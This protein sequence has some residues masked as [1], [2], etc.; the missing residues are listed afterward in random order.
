MT[1]AF[2]LR[3]ASRAFLRDGQRS[4][5]AVLCIMFG[6]MSVVSMQLIADMI[7]TTLNVEPRVQLG[8]DVRLHSSVS[9]NNENVDSITQQ[10]IASLDALNAEGTLSAYTLL[11]TSGSHLL[12]P[13]GTGKVYYLNNS[14]VGIDPKSYPLLGQIVINEPAGVSLAS[15]LAQP[16]SSVVSRDLADKLGLHM[17]DTYK[18][19]GDPG[20]APVSLRLAGIAGQVPSGRGDTIYYSLDTARLV[21]GN[22][23]PANT[24]LALWGPGGPDVAKLGQGWKATLPEALAQQNADSVNLF[25]FMLKGAGILGLLVGG[26]GVANTLQVVLARRRLEVATLKTLG[27]RRRDLLVLFGIETGLLGIVGG[28]LGVAVGTVIAYFLMSIMGNVGAFLLNFTADP[29]IL[30]GGVLTGVLTAIIFGLFTIVRASSVRPAVLLR[31]IPVRRSWGT[32]IAGVALLVVLLAL[33]TGIS[34]LVMGNLLSGLEVVGA[35]VIG[36][37]LLGL[38]LTGVLLLFLSLPTPGL[39]VATMARRNLKRQPL[40]AAIA[41]IALF[42]GVFAIGFATTVIL[43]AQA[44][45]AART[46]PDVPYNLT[47]YGTQADAQPIAAALGHAGVETV[48]SS[49]QLQ[50]H[51]QTLGGQPL[52]L[53][54]IEGRD[55]ADADWD[56]TITGAPLQGDAAL[57]PM[58][59]PGPDVPV[60]AGDKISVSIN[61]VAQE[62]TLVGSYDPKLSA[63]LETMPSGLIVSRDAL[64]QWTTPQS[65]VVYVGHVSDD[66]MQ[67]I[68]TQLGSA[69]PEAVVISEADLNAASNRAF[70]GLF[71]FAV[72]VAALALVAGT[73]LIANA[74]G[75]AMV[76]RRREIGIL[77][78]VGFTARRVLGTLLVENGLLGFFAGAA[79]MAAVGVATV[80][81]NNAQP[82]AKLSLDPWLVVGMIAVSVSLALLSTLL[83]AWQP[84]HVRPLEVLRNE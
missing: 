73:I 82:S 65:P 49:L 45:L 54:Y 69:L 24:V 57:A 53:T 42:A 79:G 6:V 67:T 3:Y 22:D 40:R 4:L 59:W 78:S 12:K 8:G 16:S 26:I 55:P 30:A 15:L 25:G 76:E 14:P 37:S 39:P 51:M 75:L 27:Y 19:V 20:S 35:G 68:S 61:G 70:Q 1:L 84:S 81:L 56:V 71:A 9:S 74:V 77:K 60:K 47:V 5:L 41:L 36:L 46:G 58:R 52:P 32:R 72:G 11:A 29:L 10:Q 83:V 50:A 28:V 2:Y 7:A 18:L 21:S 43:N 13:E 66:R 31:D 44:R 48:H 34:T 62:F 63:Y 23:M 38:L 64:A 17:G 80:W 33:F